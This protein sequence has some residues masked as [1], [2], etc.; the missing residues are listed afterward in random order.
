MPWWWEGKW[1]KTVTYTYSH[2]HT[3]IWQLSDTNTLA[4]LHF[5]F[6]RVRFYVLCSFWQFL[7]KEGDILSSHPTQLVVFN[8][9]L[10]NST[11]FHWHLSWNYLNYKYDNKSRRNCFRKLFMWGAHDTK[12][13]FPLLTLHMSKKF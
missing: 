11:V 4:Q 9:I 3:I 5:I 12:F 7:W 1:L 2:I 10:L 6:P 13:I 8:L